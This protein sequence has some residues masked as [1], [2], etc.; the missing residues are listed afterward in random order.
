MIHSLRMQ[1]LPQEQRSALQI[2]LRTEPSEQVELAA[3]AEKATSVSWE[4]AASTLAE[5]Q[6]DQ[7]ENLCLLLSSTGE[8]SRY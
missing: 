5:P 8:L 1:S 3:V 6:R 7:A 2:L 4:T